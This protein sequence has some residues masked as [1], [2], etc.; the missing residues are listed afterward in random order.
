MDEERKRE[1]RE[2]RIS[3]F[4]FFNKHEDRGSKLITALHTACFFGFIYNMKSDV[5]ENS[6]K[7]VCFHPLRAFSIGLCLMIVVAIINYVHGALL[8][9]ELADKET[10]TD[11]NGMFYLACFCG[12]LSAFLLIIGIFTTGY[13]LSK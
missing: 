5:V 13:Y 10:T 9:G 12:L 7:D 4:D 11:K 3:I 8:L 1:I 6:F 2:S